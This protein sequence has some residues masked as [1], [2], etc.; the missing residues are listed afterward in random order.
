[1]QSSDATRR[2]NAKPYPRH[3]GEAATRFVNEAMGVNRMY[4]GGEL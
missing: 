4:A 2:E 1:M 3:C